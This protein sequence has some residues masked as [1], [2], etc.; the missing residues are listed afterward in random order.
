MSERVDDGFHIAPAA[1]VSEA[2]R[3]HDDSLWICSSGYEQKGQFATAR[4]GK[5]LVA[6]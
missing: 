4:A 5:A 2:K 3:F 1:G 6:G